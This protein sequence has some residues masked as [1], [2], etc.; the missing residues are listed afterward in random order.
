MKR[1][2]FAFAYSHNHPNGGQYDTYAMVD[3]LNRLGYEAYVFHEASNFRLS[4][5][6]NTTATINH[7]EFLRMLDRN[8]DI[9]VLPEDMGTRITQYPGRKVIFNKGITNGFRPYEIGDTTMLPYLSEHVIGALCVS[10]HNTAILSLAF[11]SLPIFR[12]IPHFDQNVFRLGDGNKSKIVAT[13]DKGN[14]C[15]KAIYQILRS[16]AAQHLNR[17]DGYQWQILSRMPQET[18]ASALRAAQFFLFLSEDEGLGRA[19]IESALCGCV[20]LGYSGGPLGESIPAQNRFQHGDFIGLISRLEHLLSSDA[21]SPDHSSNNGLWSR[22]DLDREYGVE[23][24]ERS[25]ASA[26]RALINYA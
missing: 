6:K 25:V 8:R 24:H 16:R 18:F 13:V 17:F 3:T 15:M 5:F 23:A 11:P 22:S 9:V 19:P 7:G 10:A 4:W 1:R 21:G 14:L 2:I 12:V 20:T 26:W